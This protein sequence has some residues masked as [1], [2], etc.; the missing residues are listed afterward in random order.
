[1][2]NVD[3]VGHGEALTTVYL[4]GGCRDLA[5]IFAA[6]AKRCVLGVLSGFRGTDGTLTLG[7]VGLGGDTVH[8]FALHPGLVV[9]GLDGVAALVGVALVG[10]QWI[11]GHWI[12]S[13]ILLIKSTGISQL[14]RSAFRDFLFTLC[15]ICFGFVVYCKYYEKSIIDEKPLSPQELPELLTEPFDEVNLYTS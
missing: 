12:I 9:V 11:F 6:L 4:A 1:M 10:R 5:L 14:P 8:V 15:L 13:F 7:G 3:G 2:W